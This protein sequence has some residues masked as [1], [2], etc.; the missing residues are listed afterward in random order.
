MDRKLLYSLPC[1]LMVACADNSEKYRDIKHLEIPPTLEIEHSSRTVYETEAPAKTEKKTDSDLERLIMIVG[2][3]EKPRLQIKAR[4]DRVWELLEDALKKAEIEILD[5][6][7]ATGVFTVRYSANSESHNSIFSFLSDT[8]TVDQ[9]T[10]KVDKDKK[11]TD[12]NIDKIKVE[13]KEG[14]DDSASLVM[15]L[16]KTII[17]N[18]EK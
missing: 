12:V 13:D 17:A 5:K 3:D 15:L 14:K 16:H 10:L 7:R 9:Y 4:F 8:F 1:L 18:L 2:G 6:N 11:I